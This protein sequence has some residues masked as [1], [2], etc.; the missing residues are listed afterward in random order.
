MSG[1]A[2]NTLPQKKGSKGSSIGIWSGLGKGRREAV[3]MMMAR[4]HSHCGGGGTTRTTTTSLPSSRGLLLLLCL[5]SHLYYVSCATGYDNDYLAFSDKGASTSGSS[6]STS[7]AA[8]KGKGEL[9]HI[10]ERIDTYDCCLVPYT[11]DRPF[12]ITKK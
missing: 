11:H 8:N 2:A 4:L 7:S 5:I 10:I 6:S 9:Y 1:A 12:V 3:V